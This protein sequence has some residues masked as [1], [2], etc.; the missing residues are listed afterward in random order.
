VL[1]VLVKCKRSAV[2]AFEQATPKYGTVGAAAATKLQSPKIKSEPQTI[3]LRPSANDIFVGA[4]DVTSS[5]GLKV[6]NAAITPIFVRN[7]QTLYGI[8]ATGSHDLVI[9]SEEP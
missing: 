1:E 9:L 8:T 4:S 7:G 3:Y 6:A 5:T 2:A